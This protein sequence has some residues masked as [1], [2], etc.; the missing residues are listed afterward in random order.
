MNTNE[1][2]KKLSREEFKKGYLKYMFGCKYFLWQPENKGE[3]I[4]NLTFC[5]H[6]K[7]PG[8]GCEGNCRYEWCP[9]INKKQK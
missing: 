8:D 2:I 6:P 7:N 3:L 1:K 9:I 5:N 4:P